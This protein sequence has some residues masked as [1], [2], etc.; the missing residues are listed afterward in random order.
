[1]I[2]SEILTSI[3]KSVPKTLKHKVWRFYRCVQLS[4]VRMSDR[5]ARDAIIRSALRLGQVEATPRLIGHA[6]LAHSNPALPS[7]RPPFSEIAP[8]QSPETCQQVGQG[9]ERHL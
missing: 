6:F 1:M 2:V 3:S 9:L 8:Q 5:I 4:S 7:R